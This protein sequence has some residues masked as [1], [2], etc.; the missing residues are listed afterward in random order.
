MADGV[1]VPNYV[2]RATVAQRTLAVTKKGG[3]TLAASK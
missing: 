1:A 3:A 2:Q